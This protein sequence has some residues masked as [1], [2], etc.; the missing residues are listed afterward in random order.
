MCTETVL[1]WNSDRFRQHFLT[2]K[3]NKMIRNTVQVLIGIFDPILGQKCQ[4]A[5]LCLK[6]LPMV[7]QCNLTVI[8]TA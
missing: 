7:K 8:A 4:T 1:H 5:S 6:R 2:Q 3:E